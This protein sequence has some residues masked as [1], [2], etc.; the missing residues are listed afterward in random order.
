[1]SRNYESSYMV[2][3][4]DEEFS[5]RRESG[6]SQEGS[7]HRA[8]VSKDG[9]LPPNRCSS[10]RRFLL[11]ASSIES[12]GVRSVPRRPYASHVSKVLDMW[13][14]YEAT[15]QSALQDSEFLSWRERG[16]RRKAENVVRL[17]QG[18]DAPSMIEIGCG[19][20]AVLRILQAMKF[21]GELFL[22]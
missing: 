4:G 9:R 7:E 11:H 19:T 15:Y 14:D 17:C 5:G 18:I 1:M 13:Q 2:A 6:D 10:L 12:A 16:A 8:G 20:G 3:L 22:Y 21:A